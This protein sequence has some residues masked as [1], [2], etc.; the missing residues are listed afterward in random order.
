MGMPI[1]TGNQTGKQQQSDLN[2]ENAIPP[3]PGKY[4]FQAPPPKFL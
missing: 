1:Y 2:V 3:T 4:E